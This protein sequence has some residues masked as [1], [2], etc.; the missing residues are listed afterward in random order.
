MLK[1]NF[2]VGM[3]VCWHGRV[4]NIFQICVYIIYSIY[5]GGAGEI[6]IKQKRHI[7]RH[8]FLKLSEYSQERIIKR[9]SLSAN[10]FIAP[11]YCRR[12]L[13]GSLSFTKRKA[14]NMPAVYTLS[15]KMFQRGSFLLCVVNRKYIRIR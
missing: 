11:S 15:N 12:S 6:L 7:R 8:V 1:N 14:G 2:F 10:R 4:K 3:L 13:N 9:C 5:R